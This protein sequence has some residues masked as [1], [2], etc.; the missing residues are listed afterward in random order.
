MQ[1]E[2]LQVLKMVEEGKI[3]VDEAT[4]LIETLSNTT[5]GSTHINFEEKFNN[6]SQNMQDF[7]KDVSCKVNEIYKSAE[8]KIKEFTKSVVSKTADL[9]D[10]ISMSLH[11]KIKDM[12]WKPD[13]LFE[14][15]P[16]SNGPRPT[17]KEEQ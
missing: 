9:A 11:E 16:Q 6:F 12:E 3:T 2:R 15:E 1:S 17:D 4:K 5:E 13:D 8:P 14:D 7:A 10:N